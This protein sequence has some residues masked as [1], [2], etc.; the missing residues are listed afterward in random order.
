MLTI[1]TSK[2]PESARP[3]LLTVKSR[4][5]IFDGLIS[6][7]LECAHLC[8]HGGYTTRR[9]VTTQGDGGEWIS[10]QQCRSSGV[11]EAAVCGACF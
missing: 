8:G 3:S 6:R 7:S 9:I 4:P 10:R 2:F 11:A 5:P 1:G